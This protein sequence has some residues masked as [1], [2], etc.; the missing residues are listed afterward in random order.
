MGDRVA[1]GTN[2]SSIFF[3]AD[4]IGRIEWV[5]VCMGQELRAVLDVSREAKSRFGAIEFF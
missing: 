2:F 5:T 3:G 4:E 1:Q